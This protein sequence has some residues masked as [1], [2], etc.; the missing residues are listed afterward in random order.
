MLMPRRMAGSFG[1]A[2]GLFRVLLCREGGEHWC[3]A[4]WT[5]NDSHALMLYLND[6][7]IH[8]KLCTTGLLGGVP[9]IAAAPADPVAH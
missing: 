1:A 3:G 6:R 8:E 7:K 4:H 9:F 2:D 5:A